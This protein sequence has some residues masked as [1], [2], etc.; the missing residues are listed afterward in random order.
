M[1]H[2]RS[3]SDQETVIVIDGAEVGRIAATEMMP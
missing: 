2:G 3:G 1:I